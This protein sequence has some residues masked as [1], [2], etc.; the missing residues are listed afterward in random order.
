MLLEEKLLKGEPASDIPESKRDR[1]MNAAP[2]EAAAQ[3]SI[4]CLSSNSEALSTEESKEEC[5]NVVE[6]YIEP[7]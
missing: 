2:K 4:S 1:P 7:E 6:A 3:K 5:R